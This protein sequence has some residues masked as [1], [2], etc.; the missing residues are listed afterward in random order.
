M[1]HGLKPQPLWLHIAGEEH[2]VYTTPAVVPVNGPDVW[3]SASLSSQGMPLM[4]GEAAAGST[5]RV[6]GRSLAWAAA[7]ACVDAKQRTDNTTSVLQLVPLT[8]GATPAAMAALTDVAPYPLMPRVLTIS[9][10]ASTC[11]EASFLL[12][13]IRP[14]H[15]AAVLRTPWGA[16]ALEDILVVPAATPAPP[17]V[18]HVDADHDG[19]ITAAL[20]QAAS[21]SKMDDLDVIVQLGPLTYSVTATLTIPN[22]TIL[23]GM[24][25]NVTTLRFDLAPPPPPAVGCGAVMN[26]TD[27]FFK[28]TL[29]HDLAYVSNI[30]T[31]GACCEACTLS[32]LCNAYSL[33]LA[34]QKC[35]LKQ[36]L[37]NSESECIKGAA[38]PDNDRSSGFVRPFRSVFRASQDAINVTD[39]STQG[40]GLENFTLVIVS[41]LPS[42]KGVHA[43][44]FDFRLAG[45]SILLN[46]T[47]VSSAVFVDKGQRFEISGCTLSQHNLCFWGPD[48]GMH[49]AN[50]DFPDSSTVHFAASS[51]GY[52]HNNTINW[53]C[54]GY[55]MDVSS[56]II[57]EDNR[58]AATEAGVLPHGNS[59]S[60]YNWRSTPS[61]AN[62]SFSHNRMSRPTDNDHHNW[63]FHETFTTD[64]S[65]GWGAGPVMAISRTSE[66]DAVVGDSL[67]TVTL[68]FSL[69][70]QDPIGATALIVAGGG[71]GQNRRIVDVSMDARNRTVLHLDAPLD[72]TVDVGT[73]PSTLAVVATVGR[74]ILSGNT[75]EWGMV[76]QFF[77]TTLGGVIADNVFTDMNTCASGYACKA[78]GDGALEGFGLC[79]GQGQ[80]LLFAEYTGNQLV[81]SNGISLKDVSSSTSSCG[82][83][84]PGPYVRW[85]TLRRNSIAGIA[86]SQTECGFIA[87]SQSA[88]PA[89][90]STDIVIEHNVFDCP[91]G[92]V[93]PGTNGVQVNCSHCKVSP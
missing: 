60:F 58:I 62:W 65:G 90:A 45:L 51:H 28:G 16:T 54:S 18:V 67:A 2:E 47:N 35:I 75:F 27:L 32:S 57:F 5:L 34:E 19:N 72:E 55:D 33:M 92:K 11:F 24:G 84:Y 78:G 6:F 4:A 39:A 86:A 61:S 1:P 26:A 50:T 53:M 89:L 82:A 3:W 44:G 74:K 36:C 29:G 48:G 30:S 59:V 23:A 80:P 71:L 22:R 41:A 68:G 38:T 93:L 77:G 91:P 52:V 12:A 8:S 37:A 66:V 81:R 21:A 25:Q 14:G 85:Q 83:S 76:V 49:D 17:I 43:S 7:G 42:T 10:R 31:I 73:S 69:A 9:A 20:L 15:Y 40:W 46:Q 87:L 79:Y 13:D 70:A 56:N 88:E 64:G 63:A